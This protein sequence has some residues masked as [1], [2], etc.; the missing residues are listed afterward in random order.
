MELQCFR[1]RGHKEQRAQDGD[2]REKWLAISPFSSWRNVRRGQ[3]SGGE[4][5]AEKNKRKA[6]NRS[7]Q[8][9]KCSQGKA[10]KEDISAKCVST[11]AQNRSVREVKRGVREGELNMKMKIHKFCQQHQ[12]RLL[13]NFFLCLH[14]VNHTETGKLKIYSKQYGKYQCAAKV[15]NYN[16]LKTCLQSVQYYFLWVCWLCSY[17]RR[18]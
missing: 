17:L 8:F 13:T 11:D 12:L 6:E 4:R 3:A 10:G 5:R 2:K 7:M 16:L 18:V 14:C 1:L 9:V 15:T